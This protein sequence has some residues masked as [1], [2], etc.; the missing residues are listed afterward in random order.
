[1]IVNHLIADDIGVFS[2]SISQSLMDICGDYA[3][4]HELPLI[5]A[6]QFVFFFAPKIINNLFHQMFF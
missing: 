3:A 1:M 5:V 2:P 4:E 6:K